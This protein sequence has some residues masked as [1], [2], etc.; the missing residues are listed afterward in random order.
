MPEVRRIEENHY[1]IIIWQSTESLDELLKEAALNEKDYAEYCSFQSE[2]R[3]REWVTVRTALRHL[4]PGENA[5]ITYDNNRRPHLIGSKSISISHSG[6]YIAVMVADE[7]HIGIDIEEIHP[8]IDV[9]AKKFVNEEEFTF[10]DQKNRFEKLHVIWGAKEV[11]YKIYSR[12]GVDFKKDLHV[13]QFEYST[14]G[15]CKAFIKKFDLEES[16][17]VYYESLG[18]YMIAY[19]GIDR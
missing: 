13:N 10:I 2:T 9:L 11:L 15:E 6:P 8:R 3:K 17:I 7:K 4:L 19:A 12:G 18:G 1:K 16:F 5:G 14:K